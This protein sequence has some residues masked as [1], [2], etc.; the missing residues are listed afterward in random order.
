[1]SLVMAVFDFRGDTALLLERYDEVVEQVVAVSSGRPIVHLAVPREYGLM[2][3][4]VWD[5][6]DALD[7]FVKNDDFHRVVAEG[8]L[9]E[10]QIRIY[11]VHSL[12]WPVAQMPLYR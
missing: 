10:P 1:V 4:D 5:S 9:P 8:G 3:C 12:G 6:E 7:R 11:P 2:V